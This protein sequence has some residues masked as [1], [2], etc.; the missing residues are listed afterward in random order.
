MNALVS[1]VISFLPFILIFYF[2]LIRPQ[3]KQQKQISDML[4]ALK[5]GDEIVTVGGI[6]GKIVSLKDDLVFIETGYANDRCFLKFQ[7]AAVGKILKSASEPDN[8]DNVKD[9]E[10]ED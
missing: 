5:K 9:K 10:F 4:A 2:L 7:K 8:L 1:T 6:V 3:K